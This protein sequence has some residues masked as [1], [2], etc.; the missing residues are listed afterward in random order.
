MM[1]GP[2]PAVW[3]WLIVATLNFF[4]VLSMAELASAYPLAGGPY[5]W[6][7]CPIV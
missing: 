2:V 7:S 5:F 1:G 3:G 4:V 6:Y